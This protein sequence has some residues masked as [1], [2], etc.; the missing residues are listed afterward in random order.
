MRLAGIVR[1]SVVDGI[2]IRDV[3]FLQGCSHRCKGCHN[4]ST[5][6]YNCGTIRSSRSI[7]EELSDS[8]NDITISGGEPL[9]QYCALI[10]LLIFIKSVGKHIWLYTGNTVDLTKEIYRTL[11]KYVDVI[12]DGEFVEELKDKTLRFRGSSNQRVIDMKKSLEENKI[13]LWSDEY[14]TIV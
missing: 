4:P 9:D 5:W 11:G 1:D 6:S 10:R 7:V 13:V 2:G 8:S 12:V 14:E 3:I